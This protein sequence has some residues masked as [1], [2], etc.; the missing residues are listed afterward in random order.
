[1]IGP[2]ALCGV[3]VAWI[4]KS[5]R[6]HAGHAGRIV[7]SAIGAA[8]DR[9]DNLVQTRLGGDSALRLLR[10][11]ADSRTDNPRT[12][13]RVELALRELVEADPGFG[14]EL[15]E[16]VAQ[17][18]PEAEAAGISVGRDYI[19]N[20]GSGTMLVHTGSGSI[21]V[22]ENTVAKGRENGA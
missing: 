2:E 7:N 13:Q 14:A 19:Q 8:L 9:L 10:N 1:M 16:L 21:R 3:A 20:S 4:W 11:E 15:R 6:I 18:E 5:A 17:L 22:S 12:R